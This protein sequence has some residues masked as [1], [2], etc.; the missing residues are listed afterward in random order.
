MFSAIQM[1]Q[2]NKNLYEY[3]ENEE[4]DAIVKPLFDA[5]GKTEQSH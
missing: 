4:A 3:M 2:L 5:E 1:N